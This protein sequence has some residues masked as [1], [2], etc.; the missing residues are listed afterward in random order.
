MKVVFSIENKNKKWVFFSG[1]IMYFFFEGIFM[2]YV[3]CDI[4]FHPVTQNSGIAY[5][6][7]SKLIAFNVEL[8]HFF[9]LN[10]YVH[11]SGTK[12]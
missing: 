11:T 4:T 8:S 7:I 5:E 10:E 6:N 3:W 2:G 1:E 12:C 9:F